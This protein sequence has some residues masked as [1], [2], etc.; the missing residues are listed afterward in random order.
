LYR[1]GIWTNSNR[2]FEENTSDNATLFRNAITIRTTPP[3]A[4]K[5]AQ[6]KTSKDDDGWDDWDDDNWDDDG[7][8]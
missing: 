5:K 7:D 6:K 8:W 4:E 3:A 1:V 2:A